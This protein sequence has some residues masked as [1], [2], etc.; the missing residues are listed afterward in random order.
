[1]NMGKCNLI[2]N[3][4][5]EGRKTYASHASPNSETIVLR[6]NA[7]VGTVTKDYGAVARRANNGLQIV[8]TYLR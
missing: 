3:V 2:L 7:D 1:M 8:V 5:D 6:A 4:S